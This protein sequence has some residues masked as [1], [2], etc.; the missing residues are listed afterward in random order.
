MRRLKIF[1]DKSFAGIFSENE[2][3]YTIEYNPTYNGEPISLT[4]P[5]VEKKFEFNSFP[6]FFDGLLPEGIMLETL[7]K[8]YKIDR[9]DY[10]SQLEIVGADL[11]GNISVEKINE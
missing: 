11:V 1:V 10:F 4:L 6:S 2:N 7:L 8:K 3:Q 5:V 9:N